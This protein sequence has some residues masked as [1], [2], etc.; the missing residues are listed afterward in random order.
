MNFVEDVLEGF[1]AARPALISVNENGHLTIAT[2]QQFQ[3]LD[4]ASGGNLAVTP[5]LSSAILTRALRSQSLTARSVEP[6]SVVDAGQRIFGSWAGAVAAANG[7][8]SLEVLLLCDRVDEWLVASL[9][10][11]EG[12]ALV[13]VARGELVLNDGQLGVTLIEIVIVVAVLGI[14]GTGVGNRHAELVGTRRTERQRDGTV[15]TGDDGIAHRAANKI[16]ARYS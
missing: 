2:P 6:R 12:K 5:G 7:R 13:S 1:P 16:A 14:L 8:A 11:F 15:L 4:I 9:R 3:S 10:E